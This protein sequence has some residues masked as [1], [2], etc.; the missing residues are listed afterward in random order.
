MFDGRKRSSA[1]N[2][3]VRLPMW[4]HCCSCKIL[5]QLQSLEIK[6][7]RSRS[8]SRIKAAANKPNDFPVATSMQRAVRTMT[9]AATLS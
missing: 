7:C 1:L 3:R 8:R 9:H 6:Y 5:L 4:E 2:E